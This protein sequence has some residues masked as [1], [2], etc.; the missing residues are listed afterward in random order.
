MIVVPGPASQSLGKKIAAELGVD[1]YPLEWR[2]FPDGESYIR[3]PIE[4]RGEDV[5]LVQ[6]CPPPVDRNLVELLLMADGAKSMGAGKVLAVIPYLAYMRQDKAFR[7]GDVV[8]VETVAKLVEA[9]GIDEVLTV[10]VHSHDATSHFKI[11]VVETSAMVPLGEHLRTLSLRMPLVLS[12][13][14]G[15]RDR[16]RVVAG[17]LNADLDVLDKFRDRAT[18]QVSVALKE[19]SL[20]GRDVVI[21]DDIISTGST[22]VK[23]AEL[24]L[25][26]G[27][28]KVYAAC[29]HPLLIGDAREKLREGGGGVSMACAIEMI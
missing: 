16:A 20:K 6:S 2:I 12:P 17:V 15:G 22:I 27:A 19:L 8:S 7:F 23:A 4:I 25:S 26:Q 11:P 24:V 21:V 5:A 14:K 29:T 13:D 3:Y 28:R 10:D 9:A 18:G 1:A